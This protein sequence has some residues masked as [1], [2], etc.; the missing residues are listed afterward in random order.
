MDSETGA[1]LLAGRQ[2]ESENG[3]RFGWTQSDSQAQD[4]NVYVS[5]VF[6]WSKHEN[7]KEPKSWIFELQSLELQTLAAGEASA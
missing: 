5:F 2:C 4:M 3:S 6:P 1:T 7:P